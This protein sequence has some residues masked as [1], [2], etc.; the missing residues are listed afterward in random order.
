MNS[1]EIVKLID[2]MF[3][4]NIHYAGGWRQFHWVQFSL[5]VSF[6]RFSTLAAER[7]KE[8]E[9][10]TMSLESEYFLLQFPWG[11]LSTELSD[12]WQ[13][14][15]T[16]TKVHKRLEN[17]CQSNDIIINVISA[18]QHF[19]ST[20]SMQIFKFYKLS[21]LF[22]PRRQGTLE[23]LLAGEVQYASTGVDRGK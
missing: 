2:K 14:T 18:N 22:L 8:V 17:K 7:Q 5:Q 10:S 11:F 13:C 20:F 3:Q 6:P 15:K 23:S 16:S 21:F 4:Q 19:T 1:S 9:L 12:F